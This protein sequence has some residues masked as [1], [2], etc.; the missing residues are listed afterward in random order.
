M[1]T[2]DENSIP[3]DMKN[4]SSN[5]LPPWAGDSRAGKRQ[6]TLGDALAQSVPMTPGQG[7]SSL[8][9]DI[10]SLEESAK[11]AGDSLGRAMRQIQT[12][13]GE[14]KPGPAD[15]PL[16]SDSLRE[17][18]PVIL[19]GL[20]ANHFDPNKS[21]MVQHAIREM[22]LAGMH[23]AGM[24]YGEGV[25]ATNVL[26]LI[27]L[28]ASQGH[29]G[30]SLEQLLLVFDQLIRRKPLSPLTNDPAEWADVQEYGAG[31][32]MRYQNLRDSGCFSADGGKTYWKL[33][34]SVSN[35][36]QDRTPKNVSKEV[37]PTGP[38]PIGLG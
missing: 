27:T 13:R 1:H 6:R 26:E 22:E 3:E 21:K 16:L 24:V 9:G 35:R 8:T 37:E 23:T 38:H 5:Q 36:E 28:V 20:Y 10:C 33:D 34:E 25:I 17:S 32:D 11:S 31:S 18:E 4:K 19:E 12:S 30:G 14:S 7:L 2:I 29:S 15:A